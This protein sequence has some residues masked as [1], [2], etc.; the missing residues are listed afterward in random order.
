MFEALDLVVVVVLGLILYFLNHLKG[1]ILLI[2]GRLNETIENLANNTQELPSL[3]GL[4]DEVLD[5]VESTIENLQPPTA[6]DHIAGAVSQYFQ[7]KLMR[8]MN[9]ENLPQQLPDIIETA[10]D[11]VDGIRND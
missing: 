4:K 10:K 9:M 5:I 11:V 2:E 1:S 3:N 8:D 7:F 6:L